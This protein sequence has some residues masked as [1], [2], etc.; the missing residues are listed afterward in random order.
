MYIY[1]H[2]HVYIYTHIY[3]HVWV[4][5]GLHIITCAYYAKLYT[6]ASYSCSVSCS[7]AC[8]T[9]TNIDFCSCV[10][11]LEGTIVS[12]WMH[13]W[14]HYCLWS[15]HS[16]TASTEQ[17]N[18]KFCLNPS[19]LY[20]YLL[21]V[22]CQPWQI[23]QVLL[24]RVNRCSVSHPTSTSTCWIRTPMSLDWKSDQRRTFVKITSGK[25]F[26]SKLCV[27]DKRL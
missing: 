7:W 3:T 4:Q 12:F 19:N 16:Y 18:N 1:I 5:C 20:A 13:K 24:G 15:L 26:L 9:I 10:S 21:F 17:Q 27:F 22:L 6:T 23:D 14:M 11:Y 8:N 2:T 25:H